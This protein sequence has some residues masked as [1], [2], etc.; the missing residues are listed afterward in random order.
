VPLCS[1]LQEVVRELAL[2]ETPADKA[3]VCYVLELH[4][5]RLSMVTVYVLYA[6]YAW[7]FISRS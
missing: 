7:W 2:M 6:F 5:V 1:L 4:Y 3:Y